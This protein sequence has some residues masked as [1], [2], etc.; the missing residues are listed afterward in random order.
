MA[1]YRPCKHMKNFTVRSIEN[2]KPK[3]TEFTVADPKTRNL[4]IRVFPTGRKVWLLRYSFD[5]KRRKTNLGDFPKVTV[6]QARAKA[7]NFTP[8]GSLL[9][10]DV[11]TVY[12]KERRLKDSTKA[13]YLQKYNTYLKDRIGTKNIADLTRRD[14]EKLF[15]ELSAISQAQANYAM[16]VIRAVINFA[17][18]KYRDELGMTENPVQI[19]SDTQ[20]WHKIQRRRTLLHA[21]QIKEFWSYWDDSNHLIASTY[22]RLL[23][24]TGM[25]GTSLLQAKTEDLHNHGITFIN[26]NSIEPFFLP[27]S[28]EAW[29]LA[30]KLQENHRAPWLFPG[31]DHRSAMSEHGMREQRHTSIKGLGFSYTRHDLRRTFITLADEVGLSE[32]MVKR[33]SGHKTSSDVTEGYIIRSDST[34]RRATEQVT[35]AILDIYRTQ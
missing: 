34:L 19:I 13:D 8:T 18:A 20:T 5:G 9:Y 2:L 28:E 27:L 21:D 31:A 23:L 15:V 35:A 1:L 12:L 25:R 33:L 6:E 26:K 24:L 30:K 29:G 32:K 17:M 7:N 4:F 10:G 16:R 14:I 11:F 22:H 3:T